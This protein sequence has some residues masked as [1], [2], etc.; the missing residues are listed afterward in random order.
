MQKRKRKE[1][2]DP[3]IERNL[4]GWLKRGNHDAG[5]RHLDSNELLVFAGSCAVSWRKSGPGPVTDQ[6]FWTFSC[7]N[8]R[9]S[10]CWN[11]GQERKKIAVREQSKCA[12]AAPCGAVMRGLSCCWWT[13]SPCH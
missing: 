11:G 5:S 7:L 1:I 10:R 8:F 13:A 9:V 4:A 3:F 6:I 12:R 2:L